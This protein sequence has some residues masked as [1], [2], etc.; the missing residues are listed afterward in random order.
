MGVIRKRWAGILAAFIL[1]AG[2]GSRIAWA[3]QTPPASDGPEEIPLAVTGL[4]VTIG[5]GGSESIRVG[6]EMPVTVQVSS[7]GPEISGYA[8]VSIPVGGG[9][10]L[11]SAYR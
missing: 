6:R 7:S 5:W 11:C 2:A 9:S 4:E 3:A 10:R 1:L 8:S